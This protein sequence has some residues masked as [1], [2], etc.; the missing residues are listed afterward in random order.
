MVLLQAVEEFIYLYQS[1][2]LYTEL[3]VVVCLSVHCFF[4]FVL[5]KEEKNE[6]QNSGTNL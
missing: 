4:L 5:R 6:E 1:L 3:S 2:H